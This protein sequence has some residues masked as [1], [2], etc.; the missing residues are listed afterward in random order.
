MLG[1]YRGH[2]AI[3]IV[4]R[5]L[6]NHALLYGVAHDFGQMLAHPSGDVMHAFI[7]DGFNQLPQMAGFNLRDIHRAD[8]G[9]NVAFQAG[10]DFIGV[11]V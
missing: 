9:K 1:Y 8:I 10:E 2:D 3:Q 7:V 11:C 6:F 4:S 5:I